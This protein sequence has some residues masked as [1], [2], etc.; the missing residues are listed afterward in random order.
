MKNLFNL[1]SKIVFEEKEGKT[2]EIYNPNTM[3]YS[4]LIL[5]IPHSS[6]YLPKEFYINLNPNNKK[7]KQ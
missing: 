7:E 2:C 6:T 1:T 4:N 5:H 3:D